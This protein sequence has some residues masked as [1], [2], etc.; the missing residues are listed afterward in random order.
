METIKSSEEIT[1]LFKQ[2]NRFHTAHLTFIVLSQCDHGE[3]SDGRVAFIAGKKLG[4]AVW[5]NRAKRRMRA[6]CKDIGGPWRGLDVVLLAKNSIN[7][8]QYID[9]LKSCA[10]IGEKLKGLQD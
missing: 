10:I 6:V 2:G 5:R 4:N 3:T 9:L 7:E 8:A 1:L